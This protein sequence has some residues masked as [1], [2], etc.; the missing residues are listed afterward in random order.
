MR[1][2]GV[3]PEEKGIKELF[4]SFKKKRNVRVVSPAGSNGD[5]G[6]TLVELTGEG[7][8]ELHLNAQS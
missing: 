7:S 4:F 6:S 3:Y 8:C 5:C 2:T 1:E